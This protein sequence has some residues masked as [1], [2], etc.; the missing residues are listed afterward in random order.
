MARAGVNHA[1]S[2]LL[3]PNGERALVGMVRRRRLTSGTTLQ[4]SGAGRARQDSPDLAS[5][6]FTNPLPR[7]Q[8]RLSHAVAAAIADWRDANNTPLPNGAKRTP[9]EAPAWLPYRRIALSYTCGTPL[10]A[11]SRCDHRDGAVP[12]PADHGRSNKLDLS[13]APAHVVAALPGV[14]E[15]DAQAFIEARQTDTDVM[16]LAAGLL[17]PR[18]GIGLYATSRSGYNRQPGIYTVESTGEIETGVTQKVRVVVQ[19]LAKK[20]PAYRVLEWYQRQAKPESE[21]AQPVASSSTS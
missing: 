5:V 7:W 8:A 3:H 16:T 4:L 1:I 12:S 13:V 20:K 6:A 17:P 15:N 10:G 21:G 11:R 14:N 18:S 9:I 2:N 19:I